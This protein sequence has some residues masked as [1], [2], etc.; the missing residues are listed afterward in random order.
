MKLI[1]TKTT[2]TAFSLA[3]L[4]LRLAAGI[5]L[6]VNHGF[7]K[8]SAFPDLV[9]KFGDP[10]NIGA[11]TSLSLAVFAEVF[12]AAFIVMGLF[13]RL[14]AIPLVILFSVIVFKVAK[15]VSAGTGG[16]ELAAL[17]LMSFIAIL[18]LGPGKYS[19]DKLIGK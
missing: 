19:V 2:D 5:L 6:I 3:T 9:G 18:L 10:L 12:C 1:S 11:T 4:L 15:N 13:T 14:A 17:F 16:G 7:K 8:L